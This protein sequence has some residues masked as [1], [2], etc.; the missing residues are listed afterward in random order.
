MRRLSVAGWLLL[1][2]L[3]LIALQML[4][5][6]ESVWDLFFP[7]PGLCL[8]V[9]SAALVAQRKRAVVAWV[10]GALAVVPV[11]VIAVLVLFWQPTADLP[12]D[13]DQLAIFLI[14]FGLVV[15]SVMLAIVFGLAYFL[16]RWRARQREPGEVRRS[17]P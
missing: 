11:A 5:W 2:G 6:G 13:T 8:C 15:Q 10:L 7:F 9:A 14:G 12:E 17:E 3:V 4:V 1:A 16:A